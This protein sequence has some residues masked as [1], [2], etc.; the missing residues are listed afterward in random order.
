MET[1]ERIL[2]K[3]QIK[4][5]NEGISEL[6]HWYNIYWK[7]EMIYIDYIEKEDNKITGTKF[8]KYK[9]TL[10]E[11]VNLLTEYIQC[12]NIYEYKYGEERVKSLSFSSIY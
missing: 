10:R 3:I 11:Y 5:V 1:V 2:Q 8:L 12:Q 6:K 4:E 7:D 9:A